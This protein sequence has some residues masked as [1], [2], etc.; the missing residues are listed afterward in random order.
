MPTLVGDALAER[1]GGRLDAGGPAILRMAGALAVE[2]AELLDVLERDGRLAED[3]VLR[4]AALTPV[5]W[6]IE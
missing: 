3:L 6:I 2:L 4:V 5:R 1:A